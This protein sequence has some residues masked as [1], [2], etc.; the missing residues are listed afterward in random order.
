MP[1]LWA[2]PEARRDALAGVTLTSQRGTVVVTDR[3]GAPLRRAI[4]WLD[5]CRAE[6]LPRIGGRW[7]VA[8]R[9]AGVTE[10]VATFMAEAE[11]N[12]IRTREPE[13]WSRIGR[14]LLL[15]GSSSTA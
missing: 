15:A 2:L 4:V 12:L 7:G 8:F 5:R 1:P 13:V 11:S 14:Y 9:A 3:D 10:T 6:G